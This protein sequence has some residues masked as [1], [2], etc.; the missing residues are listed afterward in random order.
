MI[1][2]LILSAMAACFLLLVASIVAGRVC[3]DRSAHG[4]QVPAPTKNG[5]TE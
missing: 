5:G 3:T 4:A 2:A 1:D